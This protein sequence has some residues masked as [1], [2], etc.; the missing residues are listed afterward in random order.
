MF[1]FNS[2]KGIE[3]NKIVFSNNTEIQIS[4]I[5][6]SGDT[7]IITTD[8]SDANFVIEKFRDK[9]ATNIIRYYSGVDLIRGY[10][11]FTKLHDVS[12]VP[13]V[14][15]DTN[16]EVEDPT[17]ESGFSEE[18]TDRCIVTMKKVP[19][20]TSVASQTAQNTANI[21]YLAME[22]GIEL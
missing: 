1:L 5:T 12:F 16:Y 13:D 19:M 10:A 22:T 18:T 15:I 2:K 8:T 21:D 14:V 7:L 17:T 4:D 6:Q 3:M 20:I 11:G 9:F